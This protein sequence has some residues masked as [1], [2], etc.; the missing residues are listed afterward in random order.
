[1]SESDVSSIRSITD[2]GSAPDGLGE[3]MVSSPTPE[4]LTISLDRDW[5]DIEMMGHWLQKC[6]TEHGGACRRPFGLNPLSMGLPKY[7][8]D[9]R[10]QC[11]TIA[12]PNFRYAALSY[13][14]GGVERLQTTG[15]NLDSLMQEAS[16]KSRWDKIPKTIRQAI[17]LAQQLG[18]YYVWV[19]AL[20]IIQDNEES[21]HTEIHVMAGIY[22]NSYLTLIAGNGWD[23][24][25]GL[26]GI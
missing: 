17:G 22:A 18:I 21:K 13:V 8:I 12:Q 1:M 23:A 16:L 2:E 11:L 20:C 15:R 26:R 14:W 7:L 4:F 24:N 19:D 10:K 3:D 9:I 6:D 25:H 5:I